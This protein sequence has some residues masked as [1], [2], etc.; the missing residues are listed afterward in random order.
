MDGEVWWF[1]STIEVWRI[2]CEMRCVFTGC[3]NCGVGA[4]R[5]EI[6]H[7]LGTVCKQIEV[8]KGRDLHGFFKPMMNAD[9][10]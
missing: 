3:E 10:K 4:L 6:A 8:A 7:Q 9:V 2:V 5:G 1:D